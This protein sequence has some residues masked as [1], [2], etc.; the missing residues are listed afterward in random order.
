MWFMT[1]RPMKE[2]IKDLK[3][4]LS[5]SEW[6]RL[7]STRDLSSLIEEK[8]LLEHEL[9][10]ALLLLSSS[11]SPSPPLSVSPFHAS[12]GSKKEGEGEEES[13]RRVSESV[14]DHLVGLVKGSKDLESLSLSLLSCFSFLSSFSS[15]LECSALSPSLRRDLSRCLSS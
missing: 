3:S 8:N 11:S 6:I 10:E 2:E 4:R 5:L 9:R 13:L 7:E 12:G 14:A 15:L 1:V